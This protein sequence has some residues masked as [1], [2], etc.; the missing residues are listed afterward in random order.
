MGLAPRLIGATL[1]TD[2]TPGEYDGRRLPID[3]LAS[4]LTMP[5][6]WLPSIGDEHPFWFT[7]ADGGII[8]ND[9]FEY[10]RFSLKKRLTRGDSGKPTREEQ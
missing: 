3:A 5:P 1:G 9:P 6:A 10:A 4:D 7:T 8:D 2:S